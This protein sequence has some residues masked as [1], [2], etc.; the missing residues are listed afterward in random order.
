MIGCV[1]TDIHRQPTQHCL[2]R[3][4][5]TLSQ[6]RL[7][8]LRRAII[9]LTDER[10]TVDKTPDRPAQKVPEAFT[11]IGFNFRQPVSAETS[12]PKEVTR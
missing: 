1:L 3:M 10:L 12:Y 11:G 5:T 6:K 4:P 2:P 9:Y 7:N 8:T